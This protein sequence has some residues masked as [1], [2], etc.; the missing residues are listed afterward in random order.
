M[1]RDRSSRIEAILP[2]VVVAAGSVAVAA[3]LLYH[4]SRMWAP[5]SEALK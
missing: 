1:L 5:F 2:Y 4:L 3:I